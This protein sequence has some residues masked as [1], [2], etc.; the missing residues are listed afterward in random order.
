M[1]I[2]R[3]QRA[4]LFHIQPFAVISEESM[5]PLCEKYG[6]KWVMHENLPVGAKKNYGLSE[7]LKLDW[8]Y[9]VELGS[10]DVFK[11]EYLN[12]IVPFLGKG[13]FFGIDHFIFMNSEDGACRRYKT[14]NSFGLGRLISRRA[15]E[16]FGGK[17]WDATISKGL[18]NNSNFRLA[19]HGFLEKKIRSEVPLAI[20]IKSETNIWPFN[21]LI[22]QD[23]TFEEAIQGL[24][25]EETE[26]IKRLRHAVEVD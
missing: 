16:K 17:L 15:I 14:R 7:A 8:D 20:D 2:Q 6:V 11:D 26:A 18:D 10:D 25:N 4:G 19:R 13:D 21:Y 1:G 9:M 22:G 24:S 3:L 23:Y 5:I 12:A